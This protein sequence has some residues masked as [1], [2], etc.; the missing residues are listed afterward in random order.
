MRRPVRLSQLVVLIGVALL[1]GGW[2]ARW[3]GELSG[4]PASALATG[5][6]SPIVAPGVYVYVPAGA[7]RAQPA[8]VLVA[9]H[10]MGGDGATFSRDLLAVADANNWVVVAPTFIYRDYKDPALVLADDAAHL[11]QLAAIIAGLPARTGL[12]LRPRVLLYGFSRGAQTAQR[13]AT[14][15]PGRVLGVA[16]LSAA[17]YTLPTAT[18]PNDGR[19]LPFPYGV[20]DQRAIFGHPF[21]LAALR[22]VSFLIGVG[23]QD[24]NADDVPRAWDPYLGRTRVER[25]TS[26]VRALREGGLS[27]SLRIDPT[28]AHGVSQRMRDDALAFLRDVAMG[29]AMAERR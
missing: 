13:F 10:G 2:C 29:R 14:V 5:T 24:T 18:A 8:R 16:A 20:A 28:S 12:A 3:F 7:A 21:D 17:D 25:A 23:G 19:P 15:Y 6:A 1:V 11:P 26:Y 9:L 4:T 22:G 27:A